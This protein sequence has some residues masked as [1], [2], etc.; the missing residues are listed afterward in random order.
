L[1]VLMPYWD[2]FESAAKGLRESR[3]RLL[4][5]ATAAIGD[6][7][8]VEPPLWVDSAAGASHAGDVLR[9]TA[10]AAV[11]VLQTMAVP[12]AWSAA[13]LEAV[14]GVPVVIAAL[15][16]DR[17]PAEPFDH[18]SVTKQGATVGGAQLANVLV[19]RGR[20]FRLVAGWLDDEQTR[21][22]LRLEVLAAT[23]AGR[24]RRARLVRVGA[25]L[26]GYDCVECDPGRLHAAT[27]VRVVDVE[28]AE[29]RSVYR[30][31]GDDALATLRAEL[32][33]AWRTEMD[34][35]PEALQRSLRMAAAL[36]RLGRERDAA[37]GAINCHVPE[38]RLGDDP[39]IA[40]CFALG[41]ETSRGRPWT[42]T[43][44]VVTTVAMLALKQL[45]LGAWYH[46]IEALD[47]ATDEALLACSGEH[48]LSL[49]AGDERPLL[50]PNPWWRGAC[51]S[52]T[53]PPGPASL[54]AFTP[55]ADGFRFVVAEGE[56][57]ERRLAGTGTVNAAFRFGRGRAKDAWV[58]W[59]HTGANHHSAA[60]R[61]HHGAAIAALA[62][63]LGVDCVQ[64]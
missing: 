32:D 31:T 62:E 41:R 55:V 29:L 21:A 3:A 17:S 58:R 40:P 11:L 24:M 51:A 49:A 34:C 37:A 19:R 35:D 48:D 6:I 45:G 2:Y 39:G 20:R 10:P 1:A 7:A 27:G 53:P 63:H 36:E 46:E 57:T 44:D 22:Q 13:A 33:S 9:A 26:E 54:L 30:D 59:A 64:I 38:L 43:G 28:A 12:P 15:Q 16:E 42:C 4:R 18:S 52:F 14:P 25:P 61:G 8:P 56:F 23:A 47:H 5:R 60:T 50:H